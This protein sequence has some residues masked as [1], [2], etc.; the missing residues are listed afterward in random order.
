[1]MSPSPRTFALLAALCAG[2][3]YIGPTAA[4]DEGGFDR[5]A[6]VAI[7]SDANGYSAITAVNGWTCNGYLLAER[8]CTVATIANKGT[9]TQAYRVMKETDP[10]AKVNDWA[11][12]GVAA[13]S[14]TS[15]PWTT[16]TSQVS[17]GSSVVLIVNATGCAC[18]GLTYYANFTV[19]GQLANKL[20]FN[21]T[22]IMV[23]IS[24]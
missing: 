10:S 6:S 14:S 22:R 2:F 1:M 23:I 13:V 20:D 8:Q 17:V 19:E 12:G 21:E 16:W 3:A 24:Y 7:V 9:T 11:L 5:T 4:F 18:S 15:A